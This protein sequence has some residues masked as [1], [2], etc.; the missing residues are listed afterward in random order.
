MVN[1]RRL[2]SPID[3][4]FRGQRSLSTPT[5]VKKTSEFIKHGSP[6][7]QLHRFF[8]GLIPA[9]SAINAIEFTEGAHIAYVQQLQLGED[10]PEILNLVETSHQNIINLNEVF[11]SKKHIYFL[12]D[13]WGISLND[14]QELSPRLQLGE[15]EIATICKSILH[16]LDYMHNVLG[17]C[18]GN[19]SPSTVRITP[20]GVVKL[21][22]VGRS[23]IQGSGRLIK[24]K[25]IKA[26]CRIVRDLLDLDNARG[27]RGTMGFLAEDF[28]GV[29]SHVTVKDLLQVCP[30]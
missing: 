22:D 8:I 9:Q 24:D 17:V 1:I 15:V 28:T 26:L 23:M 5:K 2:A 25:D 6:Y 13:S 7:E 3:L 20:D 12:Y 4:P 19:L 21:A 16:G 30:S 14:I 29:S 18:H 27:I 11:V 10:K